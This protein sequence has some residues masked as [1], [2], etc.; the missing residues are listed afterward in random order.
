LRSALLQFRQDG[1]TEPLW[2][3]AI[4]INQKNNEEKTAQVRKMRDIYKTAV[5][6][7]SWLGEYETSDEEGFS[8]M[9]KIQT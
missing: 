3:N 1:R 8:L 5:L 4:C 7:I 2:I 6:V 9:K